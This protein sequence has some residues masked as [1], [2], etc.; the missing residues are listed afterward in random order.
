[1]TCDMALKGELVEARRQNTMTRPVVRAWHFAEE[2]NISETMKNHS[3]M[4][5]I[6][7]N[8]SLSGIME[9]DMRVTCGI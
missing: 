8:A 6:N 3:V 9:C 2:I 1:M 4:L 5:D 7:R